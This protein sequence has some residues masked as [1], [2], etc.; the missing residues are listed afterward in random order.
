MMSSHQYKGQKNTYTV[1]GELGKGGEG[2]VYD[3]FGNSTQVLKIYTEPLTA[4]KL[5]KLNLMA[6]MLNAEIEA[7]AAWPADVVV[8]SYNKPAGFVMKKLVDYYPL[9]MLFSPMDRKKIFPDKGYNFLVHVARNLA[10]AF[11][12]LHNAGLVVGDVNEGNILVNAKGMMAFIDC[13]SFQVKDGDSYHFCEVGVPRYTPPE[14]LANSTFEN[15]VRTVNTDSFSMAILIFQLLFLG[16]HPFAGKNNTNEEI[17]EETAIKQHLFA[18]SLRNK[19]NKL[20]PPNDSISL[21]YLNTGL[22]EL[23]QNAF[24]R[25]ESRPSPHV[26]IKE[27]DV[28]LKSMVT[29]A[30]TKLH[31]YP[32][33]LKECIWCAFKERRNILYFFDDSYLQNNQLLQDIDKFVNGFKI[34]KIQFK[35]IDI[36]SLPAASVSA[37][38]VENKYTK[39]KKYQNI[40]LAG[41]MALGVAMWYF[42]VW[43]I[44]VGIVAAGILNDLLPWKRNIKKELE[45]RKD[46]YTTLQSR[47][48]AS[49]EEH[50]QPAEFKAYGDASRKLASVIEQFKNLPNDIQTKKREAEERLYNQQLQIFLSRFYV[51]DHNIPNFGDARKKLLYNN[52]ILNAADIS[53]LHNTKIQGI[54]PAY[55]QVLLSWQ[56]QVS[57]TFVYMP[58]NELLNRQF[59]II[60]AGIDA[61]KKNL[62]NSIRGEFQSFQ[63]IKQSILN[64]QAIL[65][66]QAE[67]LHVKVAQAEADYD[68]FKKAVG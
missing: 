42:S 57:S 39:Y 31:T 67:T 49:I 6:G 25:N 24:E 64:K 58:D 53:K 34:E 47:F 65:R 18:F 21:S 37:V 4:Q 51:R 13:D 10:G 8:D 1:L 9:H 56:R 26:W 15:V 54:G 46:E 28:Y 36:S 50:N 68:A 7:Y 2:T 52:G 35:K 11:Q 23:F 63:F 59:A 29:C 45:K 19:N 17:D 60:T 33:T 27:L 44:L 3:L 14:L 43:Y 12:S 61:E 5:R 41:V 38:P 48:Y 20:S 55:M 66:K 32:S 62:E 40:T 30:N 22:A 16:R